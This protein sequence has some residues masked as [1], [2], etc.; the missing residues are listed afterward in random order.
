MILSNRAHAK[1]S[2]RKAYPVGQRKVAATFSSSAT[3]AEDAGLKFVSDTQPG[4][5]RTKPAKLFRY[6]GPDGR[7]VRDH[8]TLARISSLAV[9]PAWTDVWICPRAD[10]HIQA[11][12]RDARGRKQYRYHADWHRIRD[13]AKFDRLVAFG[14][15]L[16]KIRRTIA[17][18]MSHAGFGRRK[19][20]A[21]ITHLL[22]TTLIRVGNR[23]YARA[24]KSFGL[25]T[26]QDRHVTVRGARIFFRFK[27]KTGKEWRLEHMHPRVA[28]IVRTC[29]DL[30]GQH[31]F[32]YEDVDGTQ[33]EVTSQ[34]VNNYLR[35]ITGMPISAKDFRTWRGT[36]LATIALAEFEKVDSPTAAK[37]NVRAA[38]VS[39]AQK[40]GNT[41]TICRKCYVHPEVIACY[42][43]GSLREQLKRK[44][45]RELKGDI[46]KLPPEEAATLALLY[47]RLSRTYDAS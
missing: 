15:L 22:E 33:H 2:E 26:L 44:V 11:T 24:N 10:G 7:V 39:V 43:E 12:G 3:T 21:T 17:R 29:Q 32:Q 38:I 18:D 41:A 1:K 35:E 30:P 36:V 19:V 45:R 42:L 40:L 6:T 25:T 14:R 28:R 16:P 20:L 37:A 8:A 34:D 13:E 4:I 46:A 9:P 47:A 23:E 31:L 5:S 27:G